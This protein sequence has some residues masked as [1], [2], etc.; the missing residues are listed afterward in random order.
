MTL[1]DCL[2][3]CVQKGV[4]RWPP[5]KSVWPPKVSPHYPEV[6]LV[7]CPVRG[8]TEFQTSCLTC[9][10]ECVLFSFVCH[11]LLEVKMFLRT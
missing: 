8:G 10:F 5:L 7:V 11:R 2:Y 6:L 9:I 1:D 3:L 4:L